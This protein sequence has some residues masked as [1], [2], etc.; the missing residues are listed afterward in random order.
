MIDNFKHKVP[1]IQEI[2]LLC[3][4]CLNIAIL[5]SLGVIVLVRSQKISALLISI[6]ATESGIAILLQRISIFLL[7]I[8]AIESGILLL[9]LII[10]RRK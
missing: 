2:I 7:S 10:F 5:F 8:S 9:F 1:S 3:F 6:S 4:N